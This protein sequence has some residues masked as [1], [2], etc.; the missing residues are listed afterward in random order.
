MPKRTNAF[1]DLI[2]LLEHQLAPAGARVFESEASTET[3]E[4]GKCERSILLLRGWSASIPCAL[5]LKLLIMRGKLPRLG[6]SILHRSTRI[7]RSTNPLLS[8]GPASSAQR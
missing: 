7:F 2:A 3:L 5:A 4:L 1:Q 6:L 8:L